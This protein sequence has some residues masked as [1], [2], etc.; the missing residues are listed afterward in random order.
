MTMNKKILSFG[1][2]TVLLCPFFTSAQ[3]AQFASLSSAKTDTDRAIAH[4]AL[5]NYVIQ[6]LNDAL[7]TEDL[8]PL[9]SNWPGLLS[10]CE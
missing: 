7:T 4:Q 3:T 10:C 2:F 8:E 5:K 6:N 1:F 9:I